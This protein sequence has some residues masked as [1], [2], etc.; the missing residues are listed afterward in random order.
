LDYQSILAHLNL[1]AVLPNLETL[2][3]SDDQAAAL[4]KKKNICI[5]FWVRNGPDAFVRFEQGAC[6]VG[7]GDPGR[8][9]VLLFFMS[10]RH[11]NKMF[12]GQS[13]PIPL[14]GVTKI[15]FLTKEFQAITDR[16]EYF[17]KPT[18]ASINDPDYMALNTRLMMETAGRGIA[19]LCETDP[20]AKAL[21]AGIPDGPVLMKV[22]PDGP[23]ISLDF[24]GGQAQMT[25]DEVAAPM[26][27]MFMKDGQIANNLL[28][29]KLD[30]FAAIALGDVLIRG[31]TPMLDA[32]DLILDRI[33]HYLN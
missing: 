11:L 6:R 31:Q 22:L 13:N 17:L 10:C 20:M 16:M 27:C 33:A 4:A 8:T 3:A 14:K 9:D 15:G 21:A 19:V 29:Q 18:E 30:P 7:H 1:R 2:V 32:M 28:N 5:R 26:A 12:D 23:A 24:H 25:A